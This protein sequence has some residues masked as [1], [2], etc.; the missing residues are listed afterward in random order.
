[1]VRDE[2]LRPLGD[3]GQIADAQL[4][5]P[6]QR[7]RERQSR[8]IGK[9]MRPAR[10]RLRYVSVETVRAETLRHVKVEAEK[11]AAVAGHLNILTGIGLSAATAHR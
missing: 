3:P 1:M 11:I 8:R 9:S 5:R 7:R 4:I 2:V 10:G 6:G